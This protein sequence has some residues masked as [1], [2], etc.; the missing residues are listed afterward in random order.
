MIIIRSGR[1]PPGRH[2]EDISGRQPGRQK[3][4]SILSIVIKAPHTTLYLTLVT[5]ISNY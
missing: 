2:T 5:V 1:Q 4:G 3:P